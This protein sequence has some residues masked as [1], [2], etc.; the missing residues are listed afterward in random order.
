MA[1]SDHLGGEVVSEGE[2]GALADANSTETR[3]S[4]RKYFFFF[5]K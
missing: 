3:D 4:G 1:R 2:L 5:P